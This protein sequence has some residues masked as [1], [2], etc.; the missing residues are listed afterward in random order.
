MGGVSWTKRG[1]NFT[2]TAVC[3]FLWQPSLSNAN[4]TAR[5]ETH[6]RSTRAH[7]NRAAFVDVGL[8]IQR[9]TTENESTLAQRRRASQVTRREGEFLWLRFI[10]TFFTSEEP[11]PS[12]AERSNRVK[13]T[14]PSSSSS[15]SRVSEAQTGRTRTSPHLMRAITRGRRHK[16]GK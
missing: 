16:D 11:L 3:V 6:R 10:S 13:R 14:F 1:S 5:T 12:P 4:L 15:S 8:S 9:N 2:D 7:G